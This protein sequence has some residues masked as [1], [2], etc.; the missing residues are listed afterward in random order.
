MPAVKC[1]KRICERH[2]QILGLVW[3][4]RRSRGTGRFDVAGLVLFARQRKHGIKD[5]I[6]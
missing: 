4:S 5:G 2:E 1:K 6:D 3:E